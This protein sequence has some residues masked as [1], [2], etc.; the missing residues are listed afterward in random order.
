MG[1]TGCP[2]RVLLITFNKRAGTAR[3]TNIN[4]IPLK[5]VIPHRCDLIVTFIY[6]N[7]LVFFVPLV[8]ISSILIRKS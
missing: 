1:G 4:L 8:A 5:E 3:S 6:K 7:H 2:K